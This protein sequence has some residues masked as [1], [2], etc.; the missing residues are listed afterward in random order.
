VLGAGLA[1]APALLALAFVPSDPERTVAALAGVALGAIVF[2][3]TL[4]T[5]MTSGTMLNFRPDRIVGAIRH[6]GPAYGLVVILLLVGP[7][8]YLGGLWGVMYMMFAAFVKGMAN[9][10]FAGSIGIGA[11]LAGIFMTHWGCAALGMLYRAHHVKFPWVLQRHT[12][13]NRTT[14]P[15]RRRGMPGS[16]SRAAAS[17]QARG[18]KPAGPGS[19]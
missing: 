15:P 11:L 18:G 16:N 17:G 6:C 2:P 10:A 1:F 8:L 19:K 3:A 9:P 4:L 13:R 12:Y 5:A 7:I 14:L